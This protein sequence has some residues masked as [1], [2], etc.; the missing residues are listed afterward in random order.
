MKL[1][2]ITNIIKF[3]TKVEIIQQDHY[4]FPDRKNDFPL[5]VNPDFQYGNHRAIEDYAD[6]DVRMITCKDN[7][8]TI[9]ICKGE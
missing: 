5:I 4:H 1:R 2:D 3:G 8:L 6:Y 7:Y 9:Y